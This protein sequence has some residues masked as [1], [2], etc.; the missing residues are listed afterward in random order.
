MAKYL[1]FKLSYQKPKSRRRTW[2][3]SSL[4]L[5]SLY[6]YFVC[7]SCIA[8]LCKKKKKKTPVHN[9]FIVNVEVCEKL[10]LHTITL[11]AIE[12]KTCDSFVWR[13]FLLW[14][15]LP[16]VWFFFSLDTFVYA[17]RYI[18]IQIELKNLLNCSNS[19]L[20]CP[21]RTQKKKNKRSNTTTERTS[22]ENHVREREIE[23]KIWFSVA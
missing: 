3:V 4:L 21:G 23:R 6:V 2:E 15:L 18:L 11:R 1:I 5:Y 13:I 17:S 20:T 9:V 14:L 22:V 10:N 19:W 16:L 7:F 12:R 8:A